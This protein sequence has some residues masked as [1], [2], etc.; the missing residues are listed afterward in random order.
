[1]YDIN[2]P[3]DEQN[4]NDSSNSK[5]ND[6]ETTYNIMDISLKFTVDNLNKVLFPL[7]NINNAN[8]AIQLPSEIAKIEIFNKLPDK[9]FLIG[10]GDDRYILNLE[11]D[12]SGKRIALARYLAYAFLLTLKY[13]CSIDPNT[14]KGSK[15]PQDLEKLKESIDLKALDDIDDIDDFEYH[16]N[17]DTFK[18]HEVPKDTKEPKKSK[19]R[20]KIYFY[21]VRTVVV[22]PGYVRL[23]NNVYT[24]KKSL[25]YSTEQF[26][27]GSIVKGKE[28]LEE[29]KQ[30][31][32]ANPKSVFSPEFLLKAAMIPLC[33]IPKES[34]KEF[35][36]VAAPFV[37]SVFGN[38]PAQDLVSDIVKF[39]SGL[40]LLYH[41]NDEMKGLLSRGL[42]METY[43]DIIN[44]LSKGEYFAQI[45]AVNDLKAKNEALANEKEAWANEKEAW[46]NEKEALVNKN[47][48]LVNK[49]EALVNKN[50]AMV[51]EKDTL[52]NEKDALVNEN[53]KLA[54]MLASAEA[55]SSKKRKD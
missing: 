38:Y 53:L 33:D 37:F 52:V 24:D 29:L 40:F 8:N 6:N 10:E 4:N 32:E 35:S 20:K 15:G 2:I 26:S 7:L 12:S 34:I 1:M 47:E 44:V 51:N 23:P 11:F 19:K 50:E 17:N 55:M 5:Q 36:R 54:K 28:I 16:D 25:I 46:A 18:D 45:Q 39:A 30:K 14:F 3:H 43:A 41:T 21:P 9:V 31:S 13:S 22:Y 48:A 49:N 42:G 27:L